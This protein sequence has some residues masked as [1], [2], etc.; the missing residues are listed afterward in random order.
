MYWMSWRF[1][2]FGP[3]DFLHAMF[4]YGET[5][6]SLKYDK[7][8]PLWLT[9]NIPNGVVM[10]TSMVIG[11]KLSPISHREWLAV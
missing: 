3:F 10:G 8:L 11:G 2:R 9:Y 5:I 4:G 7:G 6:L 1:D